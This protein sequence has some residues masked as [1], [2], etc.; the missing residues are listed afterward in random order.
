MCEDRQ[1]P[2]E[3][4]TLRYGGV[5][6]SPIVTGAK[7]DRT[8]N[9]TDEAEAMKWLDR[10][11]KFTKG[12]IPD[13]HACAVFIKDMLS[14]PRLPMP[15]ELT[16]SM[17]EEIWQACSPAAIH[18]DLARHIVSAMHAELT[19]PKPKTKEVDV[20][21]VEWAYRINDGDPWQPA[22]RNES[23]REE[24]LEYAR[25]VTRGDNASCISVTGPHK[26]TVPA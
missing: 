4:E 5:T 8:M 7:E 21:R 11:I 23:S 25:R 13:E 15:G 16:D 20:W 12:S 9:Q 1:I 18:R 10:C 19:K 6:L 2:P 26:Q 17:V 22:G 14:L 24:A 3:S